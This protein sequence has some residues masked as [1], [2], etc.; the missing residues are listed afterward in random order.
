LGPDGLGTAAQG[1]GREGAE[2]VD[3]DYALG[4]LAFIGKVVFG[5]LSVSL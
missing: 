3:I 4:R 1:R 2:S 5:R